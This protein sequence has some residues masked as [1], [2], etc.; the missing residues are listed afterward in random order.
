M[1]ERNP[2][3]DITKELRAQ[4]AE[5]REGIK[6]RDALIAAAKTILALRA[7]IQA[8]KNIN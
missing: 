7:E 8:Y 4:L 6:G 5:A 1:A 2:K 3:Q